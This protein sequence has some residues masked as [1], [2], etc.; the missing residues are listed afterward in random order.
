MVRRSPSPEDLF[1]AGELPAL[2]AEGE[3]DWPPEHTS[4]DSNRVTFWELGPIPPG[5]VL[6]FVEESEEEDQEPAIIAVAATGSEPKDSTGVFIRVKFLGSDQ[7]WGKAW[8]VSQF[9]R[10]K[11]GI[12]IRR[13]GEQCPRSDAVPLTE[14]GY[15][16]PGMFRGD[17]VEKRNVKEY[18]KLLKGLQEPVAPEQ[19]LIVEDGAEQK[20]SMLRQRLLQARGKAAPAPAR[21]VS[22]APLPPK[23]ILKRPHNTVKREKEETLEVSSESGASIVK[24]PKTAKGVGS[25]LYAAIEKQAH[26]GQA[27][28]VRVPPKA[29]KS[30]AALALLRKKK[31]KKKKVK[32]KK[33]KSSSSDGSSS[34]YSQSSSDSSLKP[35][36]Q[37]K[38]EKRPG[39]VFR[40]LLN[41]VRLSL[42][43]MSLADPED[44][45]GAAAVNSSAKVT[46]YF[47]IMVRP[48]LASRP[49]DEK[50]LYSLAVALDTL[51]SGNLEKIADLLAGRYMAVETAA[52]DGNWDTARW[53]EVAKLEEKGSAPT[54]ILLAGSTPSTD[55]GPC[56]W[57]WIL[58]K[59]RHWLGSWTVSRWWTMGRLV[60]S[61]P[62][63]RK[64]GQARKRKREEKQSRKERIRGQLVG[65]HAKRLRQERRGQEVRGGDMMHAPLTNEV[66][67]RWAE[68]LISSAFA[69]V[70]TAGDLQPPLCMEG[71]SGSAEGSG[72]AAASLLEVPAGDGGPVSPDRFGPAGPMESD[73]RE[74]LLGAS[75]LGQMGPSFAGAWPGGLFLKEW[76]S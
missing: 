16:P 46:S 14:F 49:R 35:P 38:A 18:E 29:A 47:Q 75:S 12:Y 67:Q 58:L 15:W 55:G 65:R 20:L 11:K 37:R 17:Y 8:G 40:L 66:A 13:G 48:H 72:P 59:V 63:K 62:R 23:G 70:G 51:R 41:H 56:F 28:L 54:E 74:L 6:T 39:S 60:R 5:S 2:G 44:Q 68:E 33:K 19:S 27:S 22:F 69:S 53:L 45:G 31:K 1:D 73:W 71:V 43:D 64:E 3:E 9:S 25:A 10:K 7:A 50:E 57:P 32:K 4:F 21:G 52:F 61:W 34:D 36:L 30:E 76:N 42:S 26:G 24:R